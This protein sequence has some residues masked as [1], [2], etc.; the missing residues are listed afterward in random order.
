M[1][2]HKHT[3]YPRRWPV[4]T[5]AALGV[6]VLA[7]SLPAAAQARASC[8][9][10]GAPLNAMTVS[11]SGESYAVITRRGE[12]IT[13]AELGDRPQ[14]CAGAIPT[15]S[16]TDTINVLFSGDAAIADVLLAGGPLAPG[17]TAEAVGT[18]EIEIQ[19]TGRD[20]GLLGV[21]GTPGDDH[22]RWGPAGANPGLNLNPAGDE[23]IDVTVLSG[24]FGAFL[25]AEGGAGNDTFSGDRIA[26]YSTV[27]AHGGPGDDVLTAPPG[28][29]DANFDGGSGN[30]VI[31][32]SASDD[33]LRGDAG[34]DRILGGGGADNIT[35]GTGRDRINA[36]A[37]R[38]FIKV[39]DTARD[40]VSCGAGRDRVNTDRRDR[41]SGCEQISRR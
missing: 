27:F 10:S 36:G 24:E 31:T 22:F 4:A 32:G 33:A 14:P 28:N 2:R 8:A 34:H 25:S 11:V 13:V 29:A 26:R 18:P 15:V 5:V 40:T 23:D 12:E 9:F 21:V 6:L 3:L 37:G 16:N 7:S 1:R 20:G 19:V 30:D 17:A 39:H 35:G 41:V 38:D